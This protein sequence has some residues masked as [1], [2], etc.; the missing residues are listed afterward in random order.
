MKIEG[1]LCVHSFFPK[2][3]YFLMFCVLLLVPGCAKDKVKPSEDSV[4]AQGALRSLEQI[5]EAYESKDIGSVRNLAESGLLSSLE[6]GLDFDKAVLSFSTPRVIR[7]TASHVTVSVN[8][9]G[10]WKLGGATR[11]NRGASNFVFMKDVMKLVEIEGDNPFT[12]P[13]ANV[14]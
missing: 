12:A 1:K 5:R 11:I 4:L 8:W 6:K 13:P 7:I 14:R 9:Q 3:C 10:E 2:V